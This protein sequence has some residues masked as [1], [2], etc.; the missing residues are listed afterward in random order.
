MVPAHGVPILGEGVLVGVALVLFDQEAAFDTP[1]V[2]SREIAALM[3]VGGM[4]RARGDPGLLGAFGN[5]LGVFV[6]GLPLLFTDHDM[7]G[8]VMAG[9]G[10]V[11]IANVIDPT[12]VLTTFAPV[13]LVL[14]VG[15]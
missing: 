11:V 9:I 6:D 1:A 5:D 8:D 3:D 15:P 4:E 12:K 7:D 14:L 2:A 10:S 13:L